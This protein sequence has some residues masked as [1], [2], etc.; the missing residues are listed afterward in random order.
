MVS[1]REKWLRHVI[2]ERENDSLPVDVRRSK[3]LGNLSTRRSWHHR[4]Q[5]EVFLQHDSHCDFKT[6]VL[7]L[8]PEVQILGSS[9]SIRHTKVEILRLK[10][11]FLRI[12]ENLTQIFERHF[13]LN[14]SVGVRDGFT[15]FCLMIYIWHA[16][17]VP[18][19]VLRGQPCRS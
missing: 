7:R 8:K 16:N 18:N 10:S 5:P 13:Q 9:K 15:L 4:R 14:Y 19:P 11:C 1:M 12:K 3:T 17:R 2:Y 6:R